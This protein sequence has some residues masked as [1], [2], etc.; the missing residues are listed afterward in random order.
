MEQY[1]LG[2][3]L[4]TT[5]CKSMLFDL[6]GRILGSH[7]IEYGLIFTPEGVEQD[8]EE[9]WQNTCLCVSSAVKESGVDSRQIAAL[10]ISSQGIAG[11]LVDEAGRPLYN[12]LSWLDNRSTE[13]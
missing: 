5:G 2:I 8:A 6:Q 13:E 3:D 12:A 11:V 9:W 1:L 4:G 7:Y 10:S